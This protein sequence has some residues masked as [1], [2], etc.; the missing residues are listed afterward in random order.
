MSSIIMYADEMLIISQNKDINVMTTELQDSLNSILRFCNHNK[1]TVNKD[2][3]KFMLISNKTDV[4]NVPVMIGEHVK[5]LS[6][7]GALS[8]K[9]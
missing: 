9:L 7:K 6:H 4:V 8:H 5:S 1:L 3:T 2:K